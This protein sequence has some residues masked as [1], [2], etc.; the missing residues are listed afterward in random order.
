M[1]VFMLII[2]VFEMFWFYSCNQKETKSFRSY[3][4]ILY[5]D[6]NIETPIAIKGN[7]FEE[8]FKDEYNT[9]IRQDSLSILKLTSIIDTIK[10][11]S[12]FCAIDTRTKV[13]FYGTVKDSVVFLLNKF[14]DVCL[15]G[16]VIENANDL[17]LFINR[18]LEQ[19]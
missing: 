19:K 5:V 15:N 9:I 7:R 14:D 10:S 18:N 4:K 6:K 13:V 17:V 3:I 2:A 8:L 16:K 1:K 12:T 11:S